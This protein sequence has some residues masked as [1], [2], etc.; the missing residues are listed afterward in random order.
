MTVGKAFISDQ[1]T[2]SDIEAKT[3][4]SKKKGKHNKNKNAARVHI[5]ESNKCT[6]ELDMIDITHDN[7][8]SDQRLNNDYSLNLMRKW[9]T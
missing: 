5:S 4:Q 3:M 8:S 1:S 7:S 9:M 6:C 2:D